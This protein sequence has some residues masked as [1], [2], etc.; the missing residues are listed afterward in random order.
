[1]KGTIKET[2]D[3]IGLSEKQIEVYVF[4]GKVGPQKILDI[5][6]QLK[7][8]KGQVYRILQTLQKKGAI[9]STLE[10]PKRFLAVSLEKVLLIH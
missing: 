8:N 2:L 3:K 5:S 4:L 10:H 9:E 7:M 1:M 6:K